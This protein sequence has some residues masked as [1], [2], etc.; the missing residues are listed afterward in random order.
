MII[1]YRGVIPFPY[2]SN[3]SPDKTKPISQVQHPIREKN[4]RH[5][6]N[7]WCRNNTEK[8]ITNNVWE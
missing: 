4:E 8:K 7:R 2:E 3:Q 5:K 1:F 6:M